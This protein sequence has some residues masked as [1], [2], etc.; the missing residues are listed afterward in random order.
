MLAENLDPA[1][2]TYDLLLRSPGVW[3]VAGNYISQSGSQTTH[4]ISGDAVFSPS[5]VTFTL[6]SNGA[7][8]NSY[9]IFIDRDNSTA[10]GFL[11][12]GNPNVGGNYMVENGLLY[13]FTGGTQTTW[14]WSQIGTVSATGV[15]TTQI[16]VPVT[17]SQ[18]SYVTGSTMA[19]LAE[20]LDPA[21]VTLDLLLRSPG[22]WR[23]R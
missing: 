10:T 3:R 22:V 8:I 23:V 15:G 20:N 4:L 6:K 12:S 21:W 16:Q 7:A 1:W 17:L 5:V 9:R 2:V 13:Q 11:H 19:L 14:S 18:I